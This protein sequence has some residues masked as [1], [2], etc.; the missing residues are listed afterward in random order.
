MLKARQLPNL[1]MDSMAYID[2]WHALSK[3]QL[4]KGFSIS[5]PILNK[6]CGLYLMMSVFVLPLLSLRT[7]V[8]LRRPLRTTI[9]NEA[10]EEQIWKLPISLESNVDKTYFF[11]LEAPPLSKAS[12][13]A[14][15]ML[16][17]LQTM[18]MKLPLRL[19]E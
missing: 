17:K 2:K 3:S 15:T 9:E 13:S 11:Q 8:V 16:V 7:L 19:P 4:S 18:L 1:D 6:K 14:Q 12:S 10:G 5:H